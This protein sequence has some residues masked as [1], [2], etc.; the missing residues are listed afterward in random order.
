[1][2]KEKCKYLI[3]FT[4]DIK[5]AHRANIEPL[6]YIEIMG[7]DLINFHI[8]DRNL[9]CDCLLPGKGEVKY[10]SIL[11]KLRKINYKGNLIIEV[12]RKNYLDY[13]EIEKSKKFLDKI[14]SR[15]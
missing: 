11:E 15:K 5:Q 12:Y 4:L 7:E 3:Y 6:E 1:M 8:N 13:N 14:I 9:Q 10:N 2:L